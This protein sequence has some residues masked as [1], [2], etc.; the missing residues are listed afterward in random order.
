MNMTHIWNLT[1]PVAGIHSHVQT[2]IIDKPDSLCP[3]SGCA[4]RVEAE[5]RGVG[6]PH[7]G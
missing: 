6:T 5:A 2:I 1:L 4:D 7:W 3:A